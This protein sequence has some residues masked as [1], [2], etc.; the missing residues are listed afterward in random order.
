MRAESLVRLGLGLISGIAFGALLQQGRVSRHDVIVGQLQ[1]RDATVARVMGTAIG[2]GSAGLH[3]LA[4]SG[5]G[6]LQQKPLRLGGIVGG[7]VLFGTGLSLLG[8]CPGTT[9]AAIGEGRRDALAGALGMLAGAA[10]FVR[11]FPSLKPFLEAG[12][13]GNW[14]IAGVTRTSP[15]AWVIALNSGLAIAVLADRRTHLRQGRP[16]LAA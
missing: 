15:W 6:H 1:R 3:V 7:A 9:L 11:M 5:Q 10:L 16:A 8:Y 12:E 2:V 13:L 4:S 14:T